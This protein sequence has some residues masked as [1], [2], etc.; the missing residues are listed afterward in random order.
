MNHHFAKFTLFALS[1]WLAAAL[2]VACQP[3]QPEAVE[4]QVEAQSVS[5]ESLPVESAVIDGAGP[6]TA[7]DPAQAQAEAEFR[8][9][10]IAKEE[11]FYAG[12]AAAVLDFYADNV[13]SVSP[14]AP[15]VR[16]KESLAEGLVPF[17]ED[18]QIIGTMTLKQF[19]VNGDHATRYAEWEEVVTAKDGGAAE[20]H[21]GR[22]ILNWEKI[23]GEWKVVSEFINYLEPPTALAISTE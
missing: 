5:V 2:M 22:C 6:I 17:L 12:D 3:I 19:W 9:A 16:G 15:E 13:L 18:N 4:A 14:E 11:A 1:L 8:A 23:D 20:H 7:S 10:A 21:I